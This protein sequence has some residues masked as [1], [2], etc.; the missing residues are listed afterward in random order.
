MAFGP[1]CVGGPQPSPPV[2]LAP[3]L[4]LPFGLPLPAPRPPPLV[5]LK[6][7]PSLPEAP[8]RRPSAT[9]APGGQH[10]P[11]AP[12]RP[13][14]PLQTQRTPADAPRRNPLP[15]PPAGLGCP[16]PAPHPVAMLCL[17]L[18][19][20]I[21]YPWSRTPAV[22]TPFRPP[23]AGSF[24]VASPAERI[25]L[26]VPRTRWSPDRRPGPRFVG[27]GPRIGSSCAQSPSAAGTRGRPHD[28]RTPTARSARHSSRWSRPP[29]SGTS[30]SI[31]IDDTCPVGVREDDRSTRVGGSV[32]R[33][34]AQGGSAT[35]LGVETGL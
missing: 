1:P 35:R 32:R 26:T 22:P 21:P 7:A 30:R 11:L 9:L 20:M 5:L 16:H 14:L 15:A 33:R 10:P 24:L 27:C 2:P 29:D 34:L 25:V 18:A 8:D 4:P 31:A 12:C 6:R 17:C 28:P 19:H 13:P 23:V 3:P